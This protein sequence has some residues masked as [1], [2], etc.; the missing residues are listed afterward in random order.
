MSLAV[1]VGH[2]ESEL[3]TFRRGEPCTERE[4][5]ELFRRAIA[6]QDWESWAG[7]QHYLGGVVSDW[8]RRHQTTKCT[9]HQIYQLQK[10]VVC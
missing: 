1:L 2:G 9:S 5:V 7:V 3:N 6:Q 8:L 4:S 10:T